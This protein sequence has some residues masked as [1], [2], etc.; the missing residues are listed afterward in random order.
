MTV[1]K[2]HI[3]DDDVFSYQEMKDQRVFLL[4]HGRHIKTIQGAEAHKFLAKIG[5]LEHHDAQLLMAKLTGN[6]KRGNE[7]K[8]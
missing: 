5:D 2:R 4:W 7:R 1:D 8:S 6:F 3:L